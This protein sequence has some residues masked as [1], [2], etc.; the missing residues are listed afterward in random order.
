MEAPLSNSETY[1]PLNVL[2]AWRNVIQTPWPAH[3]GDIGAAVVVVAA[4]APAA[5]VVN[6]PSGFATICKLV[7]LVWSFAAAGTGQ[8]TKVN[9]HICNEVQ[10]KNHYHTLTSLT[11]STFIA[12][13]A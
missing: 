13:P 12:T 1:T 9:H 3:G 10:L 8:A 11:S 7:E 2:A 4:E 6:V 5:T